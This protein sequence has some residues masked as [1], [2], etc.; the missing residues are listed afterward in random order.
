M[1][2]I[3]AGQQVTRQVGMGGL[4]VLW[5]G[6]VLLAAYAVGAFMVVRKH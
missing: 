3:A 5:A 1:I 2:T 4:S 6:V